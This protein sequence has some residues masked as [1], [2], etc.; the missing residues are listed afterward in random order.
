MADFFSINA[1]A[2]S[3]SVSAGVSPSGTVNMDQLTQVV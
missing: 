2:F 1:R 3:S